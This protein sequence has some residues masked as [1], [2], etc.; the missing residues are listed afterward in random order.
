MYTQP[1]FTFSH[2]MNI[3]LPFWHSQSSIHPYMMLYDLTPEAEVVDGII[4]NH[5]HLRMCTCDTAGSPLS[6][7]R[8]FVCVHAWPIIGTETQENMRICTCY[9]ASCTRILAQFARIACVLARISAL[10]VYQ[11]CTDMRTLR[12]AGFQNTHKFARK[13]MRISLCNAEVAFLCFTVC[14][15]WLRMCARIFYENHHFLEA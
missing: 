15:H 13:S 2:D 10:Y 5:E 3:F 8:I 14:T 9:S 12:I 1:A 6:H 11:I 4:L 7:D